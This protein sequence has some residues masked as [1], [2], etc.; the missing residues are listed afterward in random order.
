[1]VP[2]NIGESTNG[3]TCSICGSWY[4]QSQ[5]EYGNRPDRSYCRKCN[6][7]ERAAYA[8]GGAEAARQYREQ[9]RA[10]WKV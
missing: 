6:A 7:E 8:R 5:F 2:T 4:P 3:K 1:M 9:M 10:K